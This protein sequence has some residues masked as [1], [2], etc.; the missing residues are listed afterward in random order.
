MFCLYGKMIEIKKQPSDCITYR[1]SSKM[2]SIQTP[3]S[4]SWNSP[5]FK[6]HLKANFSHISCFKSS[7]FEGHPQLVGLHLHRSHLPL[8]HPLQHSKGQTIVL[9]PRGCVPA[10][11]IKISGDYSFLVLLL[12]TVTLNFFFSLTNGENF[13]YIY[14]WT[15]QI[16]REGPAS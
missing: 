1:N 4:I 16:G 13:L 10:D 15:L 6:D 7:I 12:S 11:T 5:F 14:F 8:L 3:C 9:R 2:I